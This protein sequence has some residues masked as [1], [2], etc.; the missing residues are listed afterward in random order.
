MPK[1]YN[2]IRG[3]S[4]TVRGET[5]RIN[6]IGDYYFTLTVREWEDD[7]KMNKVGQVNLL[8]YRTYWDG[9]VYND[10]ET[11]NDDNYHSQQ[12]RYSDPQ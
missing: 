1:K 10:R 8:I 3:E 6:Y 5:G 12:Y 4:V 2:F 7:N 11:I 9:I